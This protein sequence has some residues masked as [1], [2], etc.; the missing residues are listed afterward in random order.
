MFDFDRI[1]GF[2]WDEGNGRKSE[3][4]HRGWSGRGGASILQ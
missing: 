2:E 1:T 3:G 4:K